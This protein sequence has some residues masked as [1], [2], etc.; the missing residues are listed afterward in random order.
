[1]SNKG[2]VKPATRAKWSLYTW[3]II[4]QKYIMPWYIRSI[5]LC[6]LSNIISPFEYWFVVSICDS[7]GNW[8]ALHEDCNWGYEDAYIGD[9]SVGDTCIRYTYT[10]GPWIRITCNKST[11]D[12]NAC[13]WSTC[14]MDIY[15]GATAFGSAGIRD[16]YI[17]NTCIVGVIKFLKIYSQ[18]FLISRVTNW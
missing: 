13:I 6:I 11:Y 1:M 15:I 4:L 12:G 18:S 7:F 2:L 10:R 3:I 9:T 8:L 5:P 17:K 14:S 16:T